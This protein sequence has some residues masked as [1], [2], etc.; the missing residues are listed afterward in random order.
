MS[1]YG[2]TVCLMLVYGFLTAMTCDLSHKPSVHVQL[3]LNDITP[4]FVSF[5]DSAEHSHAS[6]KVR[7]ELWKKLYDFAATPPTPS[8]DSIARRLLDSAWSKYGAI[9]P[10]IRSG[11]SHTIYDHA[12][13]VIPQ[14]TNLLKPDSSF[15]IY[16]R[17]YVGGFEVNAFTS[18][19][20]H[21]I[22]TSVPVEISD[23]TRFPIMVHEL[24]HAEHIGMG[25]FAGGWQRTIGTIVVTEGL[26]MRA[27]QHILPGRPDAEYTEYSKGWL[28]KAD[29][30]R[31]AILK[32]VKDRV[33]SDQDADIMN[34][35]M[36]TGPS[37]IEREAYYAGWVVVGY[38]L[39][40]GRTFSQI[41]RIPEKDMAA[42]VSVTLKIILE[43]IHEKNG[44][45]F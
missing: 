40:Q 30:K 1:R 43:S 3:L 29:K 14:I 4:K 36:G 32:D 8:G 17:T 27:T 16:L 18:A 28:A 7:W 22:T 19:Y 23:E 35:T 34:F 42:E 2:K 9:M 33:N 11:A 24:V 31:R 45:E 38:W 10:L 12:E 13:Q 26:A 6:E 20:N 15:T 44:P 25:S 39:R 5:Y 37:G 41:A 21:R